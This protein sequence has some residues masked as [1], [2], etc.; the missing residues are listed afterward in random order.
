MS[1]HCVEFGVAVDVG[2]KMQNCEMVSINVMQ[3]IGKLK[4]DL[5]DHNYTL[6]QL[7]SAL[8]EEC[9]NKDRKGAKEALTSY[10]RKANKRPRKGDRHKGKRKRKRKRDPA[11]GKRPGDRH[12]DK[13]RRDRHKDKKRSG[14]RHKDKKRSGDRH[15]NR[16]KTRLGDTSLR[17]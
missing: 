14:D 6:T 2:W 4:A 11:K 13:K 3:S 10:I 5:K 15:T 17:F 16:P 12:K 9:Q 7:T 8:S 1:S